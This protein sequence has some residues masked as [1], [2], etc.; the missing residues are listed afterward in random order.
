MATATRRR[1]KSAHSGSTGKI[2]KAQ[3]IREAAKGLGG[4]KVH[5]QKVGDAAWPPRESRFHPRRSART[6][7]AAGYRRRPGTGVV[8]PVRPVPIGP[9]HAMS[10]AA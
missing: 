5:P 6:L 10:P 4:K 2:N 8:Q 9:G 3:A 7:K 1:K